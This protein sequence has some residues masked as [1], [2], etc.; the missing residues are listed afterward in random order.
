MP[1][2][3]REIYEKAPLKLVAFELR[4]TPIPGLEEGKWERVYESLREAFP[5]LGP[6]PQLSVEL[7]PGGAQQRPRGVRLLDRR[8]TQA[9]VLYDDAA[10]LET[11][12]YHRYEEFIAIV[13]ALLSAVEEVG[14]IPAVQRLGLRYID[15][16]SV[17]DN[18]SP[19]WAQYIDES[20]LRPVEMFRDLTTED[21]RGALQLR[22]G[23][24]HRVNF[25]Y[26]V[27]REPVVNPDGPLRIA[28]SPSGEYFLIDLDSYWVAP[29]AE[30]PEFQLSWVLDRCEELHD[31]L[32][33]IFERSITDELRKLMRGGER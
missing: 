21:Y 3:D 14:P 5:V 18:D 4:F 12:S 32:R 9:A 8:R 29:E 7:S 31:P 25:R 26:G 2:P 33:A 20:L 15:E 11:S 28:D 24:E 23:D 16:I 17:P 19:D 6:P 27:L 1:D 22:A 13:E 30:F 10:V